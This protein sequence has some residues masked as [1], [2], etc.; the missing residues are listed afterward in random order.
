MREPDGTRAAIATAATT[1][2]AFD[3]LQTVLRGAQDAIRSRQSLGG[4]AVEV[5]GRVRIKA[6]SGETPPRLAGLYVLF[7]LS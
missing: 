4:F 2:T 6:G 7:L 5:F 1:Q 3:H